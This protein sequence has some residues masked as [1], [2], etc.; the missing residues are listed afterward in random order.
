MRSLFAHLLLSP[1]LRV[2]L[3]AEG[4]EGAKQ[5]L[6]HRILLAGAGRSASGAEAR[7]RAWTQRWIGCTNGL[8]NWFDFY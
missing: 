6:T 2:E 7:A 8:D 5:P 1:Y 4:G 3:E